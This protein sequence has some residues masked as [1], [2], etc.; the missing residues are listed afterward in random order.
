[1]VIPKSLQPRIVEWY[2]SYLSHPGINRIEETIG[3]HQWWPKMRD[4]VTAAG[5]ACPIC[6][7]NKKQRKKYGRL[8]PK[9]AET[10][11]WDR[12]CVDLIGP[13]KIRRKGK[14]TLTCNCVMMVDPATGWFLSGRPA[15]RY[16][17][18]CRRARMVLHVPLA[19]S[20]HLWSW[21]SFIGAEFQAILKDYGIK[22]KPITV[23]NPQANAICE[24]VHQVIG[25]I[26]RTFELQTNHLDEDN[27][28]KGILSAS[29]FAIRCT[30][31]TT[32][33]SSPGQLIFGRDLTFNFKHTSNWDVIRQRREMLIRENNKRE[34]AKR[35]PHQ[36]SAGDKVM[37]H[38]GTECTYEHPY[39]GLHTIIETFPNGT[40]SLQVGDIIDR[41]NIQRIHPY[42]ET[43][44]GGSAICQL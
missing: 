13:Y 26:I 21:R 37:L 32:L 41:V 20:D 39:T 11:P 28:W 5:I 6:Q 9:Q 14:P 33:H 36:N 44:W 25:N 22:C 42:V 15:V 1:M 3:Q 16:C 38:I 17:C 35:I 7:R 43:K 8:L 34:N 29:A 23:H 27:P 2:H 19:N 40:V 18:K 10:T 31:H 24:R 12:L 30:Y 4:H